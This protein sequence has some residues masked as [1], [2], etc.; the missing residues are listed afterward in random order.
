M[1]FTPPV[2]CDWCLWLSVNQPVCL[3]CPSCLCSA[4]TLTWWWLLSPPDFYLWISILPLFFSPTSVSAACD[5]MN[6]LCS[7]FTISCLAQSINGTI[8]HRR[9]QFPSTSPS[10]VSLNRTIIATSHFTPMAKP[11]LS[12]RRG[13]RV[14]PHLQNQQGRCSCNNG[15]RLVHIFGT[16]KLWEADSTV[17][18]QYKDWV[19]TQKKTPEMTWVQKSCLN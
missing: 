14:C 6:P 12:R 16:V 7:R 4:V 18:L 1:F 3:I 19:D 15:C 11:R 10:I 13:Q 5:L 2:F 8:T 17:C 9:T